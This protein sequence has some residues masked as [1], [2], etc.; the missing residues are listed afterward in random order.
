LRAYS[1]VIEVSMNKKEW[2][3]IKYAEV[4][5][6]ANLIYSKAFLK[7]DKKRRE[8]YL[9]LLAKGREKIN[10]AVLFPHDIVHYYTKDT[11]LNGKTSIELKEDYEQMWKSLPDYV[12]GNSNTLCVY[13][14][15]G[16][17]TITLANTKLTAMDV[18][19][20]MTIYFSERCTGEYKDRFLTFSKNPQIIDL[21]NC[22][23][24]RDKIVKLK[25][26]IEIANT[27]IE[28]VFRLILNTAIQNNMQQKDLPQ[29]ILIL[30][31]MEFDQAVDFGTINFY[32]SKYMLNQN[33][34]EAIEEEYELHGYKLPKL[35]FWNIAS[36]T[37]T[38]AMKNNKL[39]VA[40]VSGFSP[41]VVKMVLSNEI[42][43]LKALLKELN[44]DRYKPVEDVLKDIETL[45]E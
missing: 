11:I 42:D 18:A 27:D 6:R 21:S 12:E 37:G 5:S 20:A 44:G 9:D 4:P 43:P 14:S 41:T 30:S 39:G 17:M 13:D 16:S 1:K 34:F 29:T 25:S 32:K 23:T 36:R 35:A 38:I 15:S 19:M 33:L 8:R 24:L 22:K 40:L 10:S 26:Y 2:S 31:D 7:N 28:A 45:Y 3:K